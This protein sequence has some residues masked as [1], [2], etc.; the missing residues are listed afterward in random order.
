ML[1]YITTDDE[2]PQVGKLRY[3]QHG[4]NSGTKTASFDDVDEIVSSP[5]WTHSTTRLWARAQNRAEII[6]DPNTVEYYQEKPAAVLILY[7]ALPALFQAI[8][9]KGKR[10]DASRKDKYV[11]SAEIGGVQVPLMK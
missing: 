5:I 9:A 6:T 10:Q 8:M 1:Q 7:M 4:R 3:G 2:Q 11:N